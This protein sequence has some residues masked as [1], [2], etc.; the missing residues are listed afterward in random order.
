MPEIKI[1]CGH[2]TRL[3]FVCLCEA[4][5]L[6]AFLFCYL[7]KLWYNSLTWLN[8]M[9]IMAL[10]HPCVSVLKSGYVMRPFSCA[11]KHVLSLTLQHVTFVDDLWWHLTLPL[12]S[13]DDSLGCCTGDP[14]MFFPAQNCEW[15]LSN[16]IKSFHVKIMILFFLLLFFFLFLCSLSKSL[17][18]C[19]QN[20]SGGGQ[21]GLC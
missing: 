10:K 9:W 17:F 13:L 7:V 11:D 5:I 4:V 12:S 21:A 8:K 19:W 20:S 1:C 15:E 14:M 3:A 18:D 6:T 2:F 16:P